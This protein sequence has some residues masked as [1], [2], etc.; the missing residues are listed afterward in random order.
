MSEVLIL[1]TCLGAGVPG[2]FL[3]VLFFW[4][5]AE[6]ARIAAQLK[7]EKDVREKQAA[8]DEA[9]REEHM[10]KWDSMM[11]YHTQAMAQVVTLLEAQSARMRETHEKDMARHHATTER[12]NATL[13]MIAVSLQRLI[14][15]VDSNQFCPLTRT[16]K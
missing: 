16:Q 15:K 13:D 10:R 5:K 1:Q 11:E 7:A 12:Q 14:D 9:D 3:A 4:R 6:R 2:V 8:K